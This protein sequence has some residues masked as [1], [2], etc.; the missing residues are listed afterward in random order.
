MNYHPKKEKVVIWK[1]LLFSLISV[2]TIWALWRVEK[3]RMGLLILIPLQIVVSLIM[4]FPYYFLVFF[5]SSLLLTYNFAK[6]YN[7]KYGFDI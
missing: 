3:L 6:V 5:S 4:P 2:G 7:Q 1:L